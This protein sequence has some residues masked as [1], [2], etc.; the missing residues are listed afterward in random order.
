MLAAPGSRMGAFG[1]LDTGFAHPVGANGRDWS[2]R[3]A[4]A[5]SK[6]PCRR[7][8]ETR[9][10]SV[11]AVWTPRCKGGHAPNDACV[12][13]PPRL[14]AVPLSEA[15]ERHRL[16]AALWSVPKLEQH[17]TGPHPFEGP[18]ECFSLTQG[19]ARYAGRSFVATVPSGQLR[20]RPRSPFLRPR[21]LPGW[22]L[23]S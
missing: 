16:Q 1:P 15:F 22:R 19:P 8:R 9:P 17:S 10:S 7:T 13:L 14:Q 6:G 18:V 23:R 11:G 12:A 4:S 21:P 3:P 5:H 20:C 2:L